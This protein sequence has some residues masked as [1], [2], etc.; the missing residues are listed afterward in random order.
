MNIP[1]KNP[2]SSRLKVET[3]LTTLDARRDEYSSKLHITLNVGDIQLEVIAIIYL[4]EFQV[5]FSM[6]QQKKIL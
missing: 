5:G 4:L 1:N 2:V 3:L 6:C